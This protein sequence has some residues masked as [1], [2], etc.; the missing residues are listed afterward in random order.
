MAPVKIAMCVAIFL[1]ILQS[2]AILIRDIARIR[3]EELP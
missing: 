1:M 2:L 3:G